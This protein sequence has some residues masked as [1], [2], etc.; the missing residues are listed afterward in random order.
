MPPEREVL[1]TLLPVGGGDP[2]H[3]LKPELTVGRRAGCDIRLD[4]ENVSGKHCAL[5]LVNGIWNLRD[6]GSTN[7]TS[8][9][10]SRISSQHAVMPEDEIGIADH[11][12]TI[13][14]VPSGP[15]AFVSKNRVLEQEVQEERKRHSLMELAGMDT[16]EDKPKRIS[17]PKTAPALIERLSADQAE[18]EDAVP[19]HFK[20]APKPKPKKKD[21]DEDFLKLIEDEV[22]KPS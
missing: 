3:L 17:R 19:E 15:E 6:L 12:Y 16:D 13:D 14:Y 9:N 1:G 21:E 5:H 2:I 7:G 18:F 22:K 20:A 4:F 10:G 11:L 8:V